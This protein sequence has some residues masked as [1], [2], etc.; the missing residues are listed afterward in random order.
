MIKKY[1]VEVTATYSCTDMITV[2]AES[3]RE[4]EEL[5]VEEFD[6]GF[7]RFSLSRDDIYSCVDSV[8]G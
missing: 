3:V 1:I 8:E 6:R 2:E 5:A 4:A 7:N